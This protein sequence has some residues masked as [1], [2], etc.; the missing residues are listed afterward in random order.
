MARRKRQQTSP[1]RAWLPR[2]ELKATPR[3][4]HKV[5]ANILSHPFSPEALPATRGC[6]HCVCWTED[7]E[8]EHGAGACLRTQNGLVVWLRRD[9]ESVSS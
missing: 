6:H 2:A 7:T 1:D 4:L 8:P 5:D 3:A 9:S